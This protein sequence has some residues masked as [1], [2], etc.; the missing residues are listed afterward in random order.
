MFNSPPN[1]EIPSSKALIYKLLYDNIVVI[2]K[3]VITIL[4]SRID[5]SRLIVIA[6]ENKININKHINILVIAFENIINTKTLTLT[7]FYP[8]NIRLIDLSNIWN[9]L[10]TKVSFNKNNVTTSTKCQ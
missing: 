6:F 1:N 7:S 2:I 4:H 5:L 3:L 8:R 10:N 9:L